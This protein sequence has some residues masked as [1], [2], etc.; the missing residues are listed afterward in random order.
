MALA[1]SPSIVRSGLVLH[2]D[3]ANVKSY[4]GSG[5]VWTDLSGNSNHFNVLA[6][7]WNPSGHFDFGGSYGCAKNSADITLS[8]DVTYC[9]MTLPL[10][11]TSQWRTLTRSYSADH[12]VIIESGGWR[13]GMYDNDSLG[14][15]ISG[16]SQQ[17]LPGYATQNFDFMTWRWT[18]SD[19]PTYDLN[20]NGIQRGTII[21]SGARY[22]RG[23][24]SIGAYHNGSTDPS[25]VSQ[26]WGK[27]AY[28]SVYNRRLL[29]AEVAQNFEALRGRYGL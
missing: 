6:T 7:A 21:S 27:I 17:S 3:A 1:H 19:N 10:N 2:L 11:S 8:G 9:V 28:F 4:P 12:H 26:P 29:D 14:F 18:D 24:G 16:Y 13:I 5:T 23:F 20:V 22:N 15:L 25:A